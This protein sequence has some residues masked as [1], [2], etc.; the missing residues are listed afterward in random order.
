MGVRKSITPPNSFGADSLFLPSNPWPRPVTRALQDEG[1]WRRCG[2]ERPPSLSTIE[3]FIGDLSG[4]IHAVFCRLGEQ[5]AARGLLA[6][7]PVYRIDS[8]DVRAD[9]RDPDAC[10]N[11]DASREEFYYGY[12]CTL[13]TTDSN[14]P[15]AAAVTQH[16][17]IDE[18][19]A[20][21]VTSDALALRKPT[22]VIGNSGLD[23]LSW[24]DDLLE[25]RVVPLAR[26]NPRNTT[27]PLP[28][29]YRLEA[30]IADRFE[31]LR[32]SRTWLDTLYTL[33]MQ[34]ENTIQ[35]CKQHGLGQLRVRGRERATSHIYLTLYVRLLVAL[36]N[37]DHD[38]DIASPFVAL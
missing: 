2:F 35:V 5:A 8:T 37:A 17:Q 33:R 1:V 32:P 16:K 4:S 11:Y 36:A 28:I 24:H 20:L 21:R 18:E 13:V 25:R 7:F 27:T 14:L 22:V 34:V 26:Y 19:T 6:P 12:G 38:Q 10:W 9:P 30:Q 3:R 29:T 31:C 23:I 15:V